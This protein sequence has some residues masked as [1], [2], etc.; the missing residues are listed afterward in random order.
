[1]FHMIS[2]FKGWCSTPPLSLV[3]RQERLERGGE[4]QNESEESVAIMTA[5]L[6]LLMK[7][8]KLPGLFPD[9]PIA[10]E[11]KV[12][13]VGDVVNRHRNCEFFVCF[14]T[15]LYFLI[16]FFYISNLLKFENFVKFVNFIGI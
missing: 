7:R 16:L 10:E 3:S 9:V 1:M 12:R 8:R 14:N 15:V 2:D 5:Q 4:G 11:A 6:D 13:T